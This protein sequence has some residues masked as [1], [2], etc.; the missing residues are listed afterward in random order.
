[1]LRESETSVRTLFFEL[2]AGV[3]LFSRSETG[4]RR[5]PDR[6]QSCPMM[7]I[8]FFDSP[9]LEQLDRDTVCKYAKKSV[10]KEASVVRIISELSH[11][12]DLVSDGPARVPQSALDD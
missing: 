7:S 12:S 8:F 1:M 3:E 4:T 10:K 6:A 9:L 5:P 11:F 2:L